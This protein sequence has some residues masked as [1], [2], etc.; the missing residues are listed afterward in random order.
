MIFQYASIKSIRDF[1][2]SSAQSSD[3]ATLQLI[4]KYSSMINKWTEQLFVPINSIERLNGG[5]ELY[6]IPGKKIIKINSINII[7]SDRSRTLIDAL[8][9]EVIGNFIKIDIATPEAVKNLEI[10]GVFGTLEN[11]KYITVKLTSDIELEDTSFT[12]EDASGLEDRDILVC[13]NYCVIVNSVDYDTNTV[14]IDKFAY[15]TT[16]ASGTEI[17]VYGCVPQLIENAIQ[18]LIKHSR[19]LANQVG[20]KIKSESTDDYS[21]EVFELKGTT[22]GITEVD[23]ILNSFFN[24]NIEISFW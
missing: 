21:Y 10:D 20:G 22:S 24:G 3:A 15:N 1:G 17:D 8:D 2:I 18:L 16:I 14:T 13:G 4:L 5:R 23:N 11:L 12:V 6:Q 19:T 9:Y 7:N